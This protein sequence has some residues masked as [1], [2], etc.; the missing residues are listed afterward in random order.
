MCP[1]SKLDKLIYRLYAM[2][3]TKA[4]NK[5]GTFVIV[6]AQR[7]GSIMTKILNHLE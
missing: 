4:T 2:L 6:E 1:E 7:D 5:D 3:S